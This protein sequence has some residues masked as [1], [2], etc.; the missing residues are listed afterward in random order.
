M[1]DKLNNN[2]A[3]TWLMAGSIVDLSANRKTTIA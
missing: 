1:L 3:K 2:A